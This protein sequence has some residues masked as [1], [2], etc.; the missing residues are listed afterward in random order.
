VT[1][2]MSDI[3]ICQRALADIGTRS[4]IEG[5]D[6]A[7]FDSAL[8][9]FGTEAAY[10]SLYYIGVRNHILRAA[11]W[12]F[13]KRTMNLELWK[14]LPGTPENQMQAT[15]SGWSPSYP[16]PP[17]VY[18]YI[19]PSDCL[20]ARALIG[21]PQQVPIAPPIFSGSTGTN[22]PISQRLPMARFEVSSDF[23][24][25]A[26]QQVSQ[27][28][29]LTSVSLFDLGTGYRPGDIVR[30]TGGSFGISEFFGAPLIVRVDAI[31]DPNVGDVGAITTIYPGTYH[32]AQVGLILDQGS[33]SGNGSGFT[34]QIQGSA[35]NPAPQTVILTNQEFAILEYTTSGEEINEGIDF[36]KT[37]DAMFE[38]AMVAA[39]AARLCQAL[40]GDKALANAKYSMA[41]EMILNARAIDGNEGLTI[42]DH[43]PDWLLVRGA[44]GGLGYEQFFYPMGP[45]FPIAPLI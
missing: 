3:L 7:N 28:L 6:L 25:S 20:R 35:L 29:G 14:A 44:G 1:A 36:E 24:D 5:L 16:A 41:N 15:Q 39:M 34:V 43:V 33:T 9:Q 2:G 32:G 40:T 10:C 17:W 31:N 23:Y 37:W 45:L 13:A 42:I 21:Q 26:G 27:T 11:N 30:F 4:S 8:Q 12:N 38:D 22:P 19:Y 18:S